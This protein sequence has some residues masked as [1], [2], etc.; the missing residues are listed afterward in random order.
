MERANAGRE[1]TPSKY[2][3]QLMLTF[4]F[5]FNNTSLNIICLFQAL[6][7]QAQPLCEETFRDPVSIHLITL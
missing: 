2:P 4:L 6:K 1:T 3:S 7:M 5:L